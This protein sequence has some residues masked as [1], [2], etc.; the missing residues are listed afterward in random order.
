GTY[1]LAVDTHGALYELFTADDL[2]K[3]LLEFID[4]PCGLGPAGLKGGLIEFPFGLGAP[5][6]LSGDLI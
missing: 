3:G 5:E 4:G 2:K 6:D 1:L